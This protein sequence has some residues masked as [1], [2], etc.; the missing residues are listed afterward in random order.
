MVMHL[1]F[2]SV[3][4]RETLTLESL[5]TIFKLTQIVFHMHAHKYFVERLKFLFS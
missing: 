4:F 2:K 3:I 1:N 5:K